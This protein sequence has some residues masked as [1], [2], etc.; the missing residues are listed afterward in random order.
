MPALMQRKEIASAFSSFAAGQ[1]GQYMMEVDNVK[2]KQLGVSVSE[3]MQTMRDL[4]WKQLCLGFLT[5]FGKYYRV[6]AQADIP[7]R[8]GVNSLGGIAVKETILVKWFR[9]EHWLR[10]K[11]CLCGPETV[12]IGIISSMPLPLME[13]PSPAYS[14]GDG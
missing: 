9:P 6:M 12:H 7:Y 10:L 5:G 1:S 3:L 11:R 2:A 14:T 4:L 13:Y 8:A